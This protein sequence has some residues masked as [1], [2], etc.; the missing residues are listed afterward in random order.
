MCWLGQRCID[1][2]SFRS[3]LKIL[4]TKRVPWSK[5][6]AKYPQIL[7]ATV[8]NLFIVATAT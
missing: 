8:R 7:V 3:Y 6:C 4:G 2:S 5:F 1:F